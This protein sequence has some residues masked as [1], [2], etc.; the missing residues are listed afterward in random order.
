LSKRGTLDRPSHLVAKKALVAAGATA[1]AAALGLAGER[2]LIRKARS[3]PDPER[4]EPLEERPGAERRIRS[5]DGTELAV[6]VVGPLQAPALVMLH[7]F[8][9]DLTLWHYQWRHFSK[10][11]RCVLFDQRGHGR[12][13]PGAEGKYSLEAMG[14]DL[15]AVLDAEAPEGPVALMGHS[16]G[17]MALMSFAEH[18][19]EEFGSRVKA[20]VL[21]NTAAGE[22]IKA[23]AGGLGVQLGRL[24]SSAA[25]RLARNPGRVH[26]LRARALA[27]QGDLAFAAARLTNFG[28]KAPPS[29]VEYVVKVSARAPVEVWTDLLGSLVEMDLSH[30]LAHITVPA[31]VL[32]GDV[33]RLT[34]PASALAIKRRLPEGRMAVFKG[35]GHC[36]MLE[37]H[38]QFNRVVQG[39]LEQAM[40]TA[41]GREAPSGRYAKQA[42]SGASRASVRRERARKR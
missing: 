12:S 36:T 39:F 31:L 35:S 42:L 19:P 22:L 1:A 13:G 34:P 2:Y 32:V 21:A 14:R 4:G 5:F 3:R 30:A 33:D 24:V 8:S 38:A 40:A 37:R 26:R 29:L 10:R 17:G 16:M 6:N 11:Y 18:F 28:P 20:V 7:G 9:A 25:I 41:A 27:G 23:V 15:K